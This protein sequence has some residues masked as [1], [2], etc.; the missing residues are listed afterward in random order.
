MIVKIKWNEANACME[1]LYQKVKRIT[2]SKTG[3][4][5]Q[6]GYPSANT[7]EWNFDGITDI[8]ITE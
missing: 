1:G 4:I 2:V 6:T 3:I 5:I 8:T 7:I